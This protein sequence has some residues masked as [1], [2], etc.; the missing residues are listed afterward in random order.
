MVKQ[1]LSQRAVLLSSTGIGSIKRDRL[2]KRWALPQLGIDFYDG[3]EDD[4]IELTLHLRQRYPT[5]L[6]SPVKHCH[7]HTELQLW[8]DFLLHMLNKFHVADERVSSTKFTIS[9]RQAPKD[10]QVVVFATP[11]F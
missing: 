5:D 8:I 6:V 2:S 10:K 4:V 9:D 1:L 11:P 3:L 7:Q